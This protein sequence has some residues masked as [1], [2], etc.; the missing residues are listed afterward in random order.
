M[1]TALEQKAIRSAL[2]VGLV[3][4]KSRGGSPLD[5]RGGFMVVDPASNIPLA[6]FQYDLSPEAVIEFCTAD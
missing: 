3:A 6:G 1:A 2:R 4:R 5:N